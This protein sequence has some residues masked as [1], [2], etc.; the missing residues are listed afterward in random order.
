MLNK[1]VV[2]VDGIG[3]LLSNSI[4]QVGAMMAVCG[5]EKMRGML[6]TLKDTLTAGMDGIRDS[7]HG[8]Y[9]DSIDL[10]T[11]TKALTD[12]FDFCEISLDY[13]INGNP[14]SKTKY[15]LLY[16]IKEA[17]SNVIKHSEASAVTVTMKE[18]PALYQLVIRDNGT[19]RGPAGDGIGLESIRQRAQSL[20]GITNYSSENGFTVFVSIPKER[21]L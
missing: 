12:N 3:H 2:R 4:L 18:H 7:I 17:L 5:D 6:A 14:P 20:G 16:I 9:D 8:L 10:F 11:E 13:D 15:A 21:T 19:K 1:E